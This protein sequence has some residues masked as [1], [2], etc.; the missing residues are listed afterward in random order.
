MKS[1]PKGNWPDWSSFGQGAGWLAVGITAICV[2]VSVL[3]CGVATPLMV[4]IAA[5]TITAGSLTAVNGASEVGEAFTGYNVVE[6]GIF[7]GSPRAYNIYAHT[8]AAVAEIDTVVCGGWM[9][10][11]QPRIEAYNNIQ[12]YQYTDTMKSKGYLYSGSKNYKT[13]CEFTY[14]AKNSYK[15]WKNVF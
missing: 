2:G 6:D 3:T 13:L 4:G 15:I 12:N 8:T 7:R 1:D 10:K 14:S 5:T 9:A 11:N